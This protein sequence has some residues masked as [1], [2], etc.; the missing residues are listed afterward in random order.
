LVVAQN[1]C[2]QF[3]TVIGVPNAGSV[4]NRPGGRSATKRGGDLIKLSLARVVA[5]QRVIAV[6]AG[7]SR[8]DRV[9]I[10]S[11]TRSVSSVLGSVP[12]SASPT[13]TAPA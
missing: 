8:D 13:I 1:A 9:T 4:D 2:D 3:R 10:S 12:V 7:A 6:R 11:R 5:A